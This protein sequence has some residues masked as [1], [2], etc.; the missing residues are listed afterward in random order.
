MNYNIRS[1]KYLFVTAMLSIFSS[2]DKDNDPTLV[3]TLKFDKEIL[4]VDAEGGVLSVDIEANVN[5]EVVIP[6]DADWVKLMETSQAIQS[7]AI[8]SALSLEVEKNT[9]GSS[10]TAE[11]IIRAADEHPQADTLQIVQNG[12]SDDANITKEFDPE[13]ALTLEYCYYI[14]DAKHITFADVK[15]IDWLYLCPPDCEV[16]SVRGIEYMESLTYLRLE[17]QYLTSLDLSKNIELKTLVLQLMDLTSL[18]VSHNVNLERLNCTQNQLASLDLTRNTKLTTLECSKNRLTSL[19]LS[20]N[21]ELTSIDCGFNQL[22]S[23]D[24]SHCPE[25]KSLTTT[26][27]TFSAL[28]LSSNLKL[29]YLMCTDL[30]MPFLDLSANTELT[31]LWCAGGELTTLDVSRCSKLTEL[32]CFMNKITSLDLTNCTELENLRCY[33]NKLKFIDL[34]YCEKLK[35]L[36]CQENLLP[37]VDISHNFGLESLL[38]ANNPGLDSFFNVVVWP[39]CELRVTDSTWNEVKSWE[40]GGNT[41]TVRY[42]EN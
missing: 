22:T 20:K 21:V 12:L 11:V 26:D 33:N 6:Q 37:E 35:R 27:N 32:Y 15:N 17:R 31:Y 13:F 5:Y 40:Y 42:I 1:F 29:T 38:C 41:V 19:D 28:D 39:G 16:T 30:D 18:D 36:D 4:S 7:G 23:L 34:S 10:R 14:P 9:T 24:L 25:L 2:C 3:P 8:S